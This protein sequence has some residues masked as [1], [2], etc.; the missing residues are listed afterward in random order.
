MAIH[1]WLSRKTLLMCLFSQI[2]NV[3]CNKNRTKGISK[4]LL[5]LVRFL[6]HQTLR[7]YCG[8]NLTSCTIKKVLV[9]LYVWQWHWTGPDVPATAVGE[10][11]VCLLHTTTLPVQSER[12]S[13]LSHSVSMSVTPSA[14]SQLLSRWYKYIHSTYHKE[15]HSKLPCVGRL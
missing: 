4:T 5:C 13:I 8:K 9:T 14:F 12:Y 2:Y 7:I 15:Q 10:I 1:N 6:L 3:W 11:P